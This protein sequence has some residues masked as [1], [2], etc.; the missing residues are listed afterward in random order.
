M[1]DQPLSMTLFSTGEMGGAQRYGMTRA[2]NRRWCG[3][4]A[5]CAGAGACVLHAMRG[6]LA[7]SAL[8][9]S[10]EPGTWVQ[11]RAIAGTVTVAG[12]HCE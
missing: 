11:L 4:C 7:T 10:A 1:S 12:G 5:V 8:L 9:A 2:D 6:V 3:T